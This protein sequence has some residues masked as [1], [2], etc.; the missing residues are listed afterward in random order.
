LVEV[1]VKMVGLVT[2]HISVP[3]T[4]SNVEIMTS[5]LWIV[6]IPLRRSSFAMRKRKSDAFFALDFHPIQNIARIQGRFIISANKLII[7]S[8]K[9]KLLILKG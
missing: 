7:K 4:K 3:I 8:L 6:C 1:K 5:K 2:S 9:K